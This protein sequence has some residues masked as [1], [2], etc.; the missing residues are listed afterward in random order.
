MRTP[1]ALAA[2]A[3]LA[4]TTLLL[5]ACD[6]GGETST[7]PTTHETTTEPAEDPTTDEPTEDPSQSYRD[8]Q[9]AAAND[10]ME[11]YY[12]TSAEVGNGAFAE[13]Q[14][15]IPFWNA[16]V[17]QEEQEE[18]VAALAAG[19]YYT[20]GATEIYS[21][22]ATDWERATAD[23]EGFDT[24]TLHLCVDARSV[25]YYDT[26]DDVIKEPPEHR[27]PVDVELLGQPEAT[28]GW[29]IQSLDARE[30]STC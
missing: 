7:D 9:I 3:L 14:E 29:N 2:T 23:A 8:Q 17:W 1:P 16:N 13:Y 10:F 19:G 27:Y 25:T 4:T 21:S 12:E 5:A 30:D 15:L 20:E 24:V 18:G 26:S 11:L 22:R 6:G 28:H